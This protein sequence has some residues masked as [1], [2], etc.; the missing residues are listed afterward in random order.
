MMDGSALGGTA[1]DWIGDLSDAAASF[2]WPRVTEMIEEYVAYL[3]STAVPGTAEVKAVLQLLQDNLRYA[4]CRAVADAALALNL[5]DA[6]ARRQYAQA[7]VDGGN[8]SAA[9]LIYRGIREDATAPRPE[10]VEAHGGVGRCYKQLFVTTGEPSRR[11]IYLQR[12]LD[13]YHGA[14]LEDRSLYWHGINAAAL[15]ARGEREGLTSMGAPEGGS[16]RLAEDVL[17]SVDELAA[18]D[19]WDKAIAAEALIALGRH[20]DAIQRVKTFLRATDVDAFK[21]AALLRQVIEIWELDTT[22]P[23]GDLILPLLRSALLERRGGEVLVQTRDVRAERVAPP[24]ANERQLEKVFGIEWYRSL[25]WYLKGLQRCRAVAQIVDASD[26]G[27]GTAFLVSGANLHSALPETVLMT[28]EHVIPEDLHPSNA[29]VI[30]RGL[31]ADNTRQEFRI[32]RRWWCERHKPPGLDTT[33]VELDAYPQ[34]VDPLPLAR[35]LLPALERGLPRAYV[36]GYPKGLAQPQFSLHDTALLHYDDTWIHYRSPTEPGSSGSPVF[37]AQWDLI[38]LH[39]G[40]G[41]YP[42]PQGGGTD[43]A[44]EAISLDAIRARLRER[45]PGPQEVE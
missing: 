20:S 40:T 24:S 4:E 8:P 29:R 27:F 31:D 14:Y 17:R 13:A 43:E 2:D 41:F 9:L 30:F 7:L 25:T 6:P 3:R 21:I 15:L 37:D 1:R 11:A 10:R 33:L 35:Q 34:N 32:V 22:R 36:I 39:H 42:R 45:R 5:N 16:R 23:P 38:G 12:S 28:N 26:Y 44:N 18:I 19:A